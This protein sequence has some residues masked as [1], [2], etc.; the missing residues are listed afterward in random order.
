MEAEYAANP[1]EVLWLDAWPDDLP[2][3]EGAVKNAGGGLAEDNGLYVM[4]TVQELDRVKAYADEL[5]S[6][7][8]NG[9]PMEYDGGFFV[10]LSGNGYSEVMISYT[11]SEQQCCMSVKK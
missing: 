1:P 3:M 11:E 4:L 10:Q 6:F 9:K 8:F 7:G 2:K 5:L